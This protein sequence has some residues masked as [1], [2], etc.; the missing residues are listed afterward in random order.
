MNKDFVLL[1]EQSA[2]DLQS[3]L[4]RAKRL[5]PDGLVRL[6]AFGDVLAAYVAPIFAGS[7]L[8]AGPTV[9]GLRTTE[10]AEAAEVDAL[11][12]IAAVL[13]R[14]A[15][16]LESPVAQYRIEVPESSQRAAWAGVSP[17]RSGWVQDASINEVVLTDLARK[18]IQEVADTLPTSIGGP[19]AARIRGEIW[20]RGIEL[21]PRIPTGAAFVAAGL[22]FMT[23]NENI[24][25][26]FAEN[27]VRL[28]SEFGHVIAR[29]SGRVA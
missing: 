8:D 21:N 27:W 4:Q 14:V 6:R 23:E 26:Y 24:E 12:P 25:V 13:D 3:Y 11:V 7:L 5:D 17:P 2:K 19:I 15:R 1:D 20:G 28:S 10:L 16:I 22:G 9:L 18:G 29:E